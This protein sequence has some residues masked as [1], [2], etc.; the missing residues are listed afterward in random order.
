[1]DKLPVNVRNL[2]KRTRDLI[3]KIDNVAESLSNIPNYEDF[4]VIQEKEFAAFTASVIK[5][6]TFKGRE[7]IILRIEPIIEVEPELL[8]VLYHSELVPERLKD[9]VSTGTSYVSE[10]FQVKVDTPEPL[11]DYAIDQ[12]M[13]KLQKAFWCFSQPEN[14]E[15]LLNLK[16]KLDKLEKEENQREKEIVKEQ[17][18][19]LL[20]Y[21]VSLP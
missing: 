15:K 19:D 17:I 18:N 11:R 8:E 6:G 3:H 20:F 14:R 16:K 12:I 21:T 2:V 9:A 5:S 7:E 4:Q 13:I 1:M 10:V